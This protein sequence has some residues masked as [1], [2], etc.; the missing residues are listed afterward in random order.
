MYDG[1]FDGTL[2]ASCEGVQASDVCSERAEV[3]LAGISCL[4]SIYV[5]DNAQ[6]ANTIV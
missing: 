3:L 5:A 6:L 1:F 2:D 4:I